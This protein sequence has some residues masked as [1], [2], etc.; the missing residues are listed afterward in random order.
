MTTESNLHDATR[1]KLL[2]ER[3][4]VTSRLH[5]LA[6]DNVAFELDTDLVPPSGYESGNAMSLMLERRLVDIDNAL[7]RIADGVYGTC[8]T[9]GNAIP[10]RRLEALPFATLCVQCQS[11]ADKRARAPRQAVRA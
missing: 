8:D 7:A 5:A 3:T 10:P 11:V 9:C 1:E 6:Q 2:Q 4:A